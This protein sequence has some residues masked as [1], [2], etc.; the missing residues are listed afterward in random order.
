MRRMI[1]TKMIWGGVVLVVSLVVLSG[2][3]QLVRSGAEDCGSISQDDWAGVQQ[4][5]RRTSSAYAETRE[6]A[7]RLAECRLFV[8]WSK[9]KAVAWLG[10]PWMKDGRS[11]DWFIGSRNDDAELLTIFWDA[12][13][14]VLRVT[15]SP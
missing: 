3:G 14:R 4:E 7:E 15:V 6:L 11:A 5:L 8:G 9:R 12:S 10:E 13:G 1:V 2:C